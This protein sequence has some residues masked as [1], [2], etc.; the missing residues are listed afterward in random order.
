MR[1]DELFSVKYGINM[2]LNS[3]EITDADDPD[4]I[5]FV[6]RTESN[7]GV[8]A[9]VK[10]VRG[11][12]PQEAGLITCAAG[13]SVLSTFL[14]KE[15]FYSG[16][17][18]F[19]L[20]PLR[21]MSMNE[22]LFYCMCITK[23]AYKYSYGRQANKTLPSINLP[24]II[25][26]WVYDFSVQ[27]ISTAIGLDNKIPNLNMIGWKVFPLSKLFHISTS[28]DLSLQDQEPGQVP[29]ITSTAENNG[30]AAYV[31]AKPSQQSN[32]LTVARNGSVGSTF[33]QEVPY[34]ASPDDIRILTPKFKM[35][36][37]SA[38]F[39]KTIIEREKFRFAYGRKMGT[40]R[41]RSLEIKLPV[42]D[43][44]DPDTLYMENYIKA[45]PYSDRI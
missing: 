41:L 26:E 14:Q 42:A 9:R 6:A 17:D 15:P 4:G 34:C 28:Q 44:G 3:C 19:V 16:R 45:L 2:E 11:K 40:S 20:K 38:L 13:G 23:N 35:N 12:K 21:S 29:Y 33:Y 22:K 25:P 32:T 27:P 24:N 10:P 31:K 37:F 1:I 18:L 30:V 8:V 39:I 7:N 43:S 36:K 5:N